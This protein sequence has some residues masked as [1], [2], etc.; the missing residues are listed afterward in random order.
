MV[1]NDGV[2]H[3]GILTGFI[4]T[5]H[6]LGGGFWAYMAGVIF[7]KTGSYQVAFALLAVLAL[8][9]AVSMVFLREKRYLPIQLK[10]SCVEE[11][12]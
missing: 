6:F 9:A 8:V 1:P 7:D 5:A 12:Q 11:R 10:T 4:N 2:S 3:L